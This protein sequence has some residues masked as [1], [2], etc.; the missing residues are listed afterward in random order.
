[1]LDLP[2]CTR[3]SDRDLVHTDVIVVIEIHEFFFGEL[4]AVVGDDSVRDSK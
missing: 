2:I 3:V 1:V 4:S